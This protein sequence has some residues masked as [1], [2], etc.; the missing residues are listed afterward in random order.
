MIPYYM[1]DRVQENHRTE[2]CSYTGEIEGLV[3]EVTFVL[4][5]EE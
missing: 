4:G 3:E 1:G 5:F 2:S